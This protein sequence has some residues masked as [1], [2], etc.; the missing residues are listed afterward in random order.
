MLV[1]HASRG[2]LYLLLNERSD[3]VKITVN[4]VETD[5]GAGQTIA[6]FIA[7]QG[8]IAATIVVEHNYEIVRQP[9]W[10]TRTLKPNDSLEIVSFV[11]GG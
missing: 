11:G 2:V 8:F 3:S 5:A 10:S 9:E 7:Q 4:G 1:W 6:D